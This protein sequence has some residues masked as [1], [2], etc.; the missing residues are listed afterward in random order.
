MFSY[1]HLNAFCS[2][3]E[4]QSYSAAARLLNKDRTTIREQIKAIEDSYAVALFSIQGKKAQPTD[5][6]LSIYKQAKLLVQ[7]SERLST[8]LLSAYKEEIDSLDIFHDVLIP[9]SLMV[10]V[11]QEMSLRHPQLKINWLHR[12]RDEA[13]TQVSNGTRQLAIMQHLL[14]N[15][16]EFPLGNIKLGDTELALFT[17]K[18]SPLLAI[19]DLALGDLQLSKQ[20]ISEN[21]FNTIPEFLAVSHNLRLVSNN[22]VL[23][24]LL[25]QDGWAVLSTELAQPYVDNQELVRLSIKEVTSSLK[26]GLTFYYPLSFETSHLYRELLSVMQE[27]A[28][29]HL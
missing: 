29:A 26:V 9:N 17:R 10:N 18:G 2:T 21:H 27:Y 28:K 13:L 24:E 19:A 8:C 6:A 4:T 5:M 1:E 22:D 7:N 23:I 20:Y 14:L 16:S 11:E 12:I 3:V 15:Q 25:K